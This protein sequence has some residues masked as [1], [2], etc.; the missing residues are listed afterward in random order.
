MTGRLELIVRRPALEQREV[1]DTGELRVD[2]GLVGDTWRDRGSTRNGDRPDPDRQL[3]IMST[4][5]L[6]LITDDRASWPMAG[7]QLYVDFEP[8]EDMF[9]AGTRL[10]IGDAVVE[11]TAAPHTGCAKFRARFGEDALRLVNTPDGRRRRL[12]GANARV[13]TDGTIRAGDD[14]VVLAPVQPA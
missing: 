3:T 11:L 14:V 1:I 6:A 5:A 8:D 7:D 10:Q 2:V 4:V 12:R 9:P 13:V